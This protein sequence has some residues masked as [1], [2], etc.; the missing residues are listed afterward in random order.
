MV[1][2]RLASRLSV[3]ISW[4]AV[5]ESVQ[6]VEI[7]SDQL[8][9]AENQQLTKASCHLV[10]HQHGRKTDQDAPDRHPPSLATR[11]AFAACATNH[12]VGDFGQAQFPD[13]LLDHESV[14]SH[15][16]RCRHAQSRSIRERLPY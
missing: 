2:P 10:Q 9:K 5:D 11:D 12:G 4:N 3:S 1:R 13:R 14:R 15:I 6:S 7:S 8:R 16:H